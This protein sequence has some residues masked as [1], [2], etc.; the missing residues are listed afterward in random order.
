ME[1][2]SRRVRRSAWI[3]HFFIFGII[4][5]DQKFWYVL[6]CSFTGCSFWIFQIMQTWKNCIFTFSA[7]KLWSTV[8]NSHQ[9]LRFLQI[10][11]MNE[12]WICYLMKVH[13]Y[14]SCFASGLKQNPQSRGRSWKAAGCCLKI[15]RKMAR[16]HIHGPSAVSLLA[17][18]WK[19]KVCVCPIKVVQ[20]EM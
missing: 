5:R 7:D 13:H 3:I 2:L 1:N 12:Q 6:I 15:R 11:W 9:L 10:E 16:W 19:K 17:T 4:F 18:E 8:C 14:W 20:S